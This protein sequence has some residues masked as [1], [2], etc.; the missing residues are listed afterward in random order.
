MKRKPIFL[1]I[2]LILSMLLSFASCSNGGLSYTDSDIDSMISELE[3]KIDDL[4]AEIDDLEAEIDGLKTENGGLKTEIDALKAEINELKAKIDQLL[5]DGYRVVT[6]DANGGSTV[7]SQNVHVGTRAEEPADP[8][9]E[10]YEFDG[11]YTS[12]GEYWDFDEYTVHGNI[13]LI[14]K[15]T[16]PSHGEPADP[17]ANGHSYSKASGKCKKCDA[18]CEHSFG[19]DSVCDVCGYKRKD[20]GNEAAYPEVPW[21]NDEPIELLFS[22]SLNSSNK[23]LSSGA[24][25]FLAGEDED[26]CD[27]IDEDVW[28][29]NSYAYEYTNVNLT[30]D[31]WPDTT[32]YGWGKCFD[33]IYKETKVT[34]YK[35]P[36]MYS[37][38]TYDMVAASLKGSFHNLK[39]TGLKDGNYFS[40]LD[41]DYQEDYNQY[42]RAVENGTADE[43]TTYDDKGYMY[44]YMQSLTLN[45]EKSYVLASDYFTD[46]IRAFYVVPVNVSLLE[47]VGL[48]ITGDRDRD[49]KFTLDDFYIEVNNREW[50]YQKV[51][52]YSAA[53]YRNTGTFSGA[54]DIEDVLGWCSNNG[55]FIASGFIYS[56]DINVIQRV[57]NDSIGDYEYSYPD[58]SQQLYDIFDAISRLHQSTGVYCL[59]TDDTNFTKY[60][61]NT[62]LAIAVLNRFC[63]NKILFGGI[64]MLGSLE[65]PEYQQLKGSGGFGVV[66]VPL[67]REVDTTVEYDPINYL[68]SIHNA[69]RPGAISI[70]T[71]NFAACTAFLDYQST[72]STEILDSYYNR[73]LCVKVVDGEVEGTVKM[74]KYIR[75]N[76]RSAFDETFEDVLGVFDSKVSPYNW[77]TPLSSGKFICDIRDDYKSYADKKEETLLLLYEAYKGLP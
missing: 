77:T 56:T 70:T 19:D 3:G 59:T 63:D 25:R 48:G 74:L 49:G 54:E 31:Y 66:P 50:T 52:D 58:E 41:K 55:G 42:I 13:T 40:F 51:I 29:R 71:K 20:S 47:S 72:H 17:C 18:V 26:Y 35:T 46:V 44:E 75:A 6:F 5:T 43:N 10:G 36:D 45:Q 32:E 53:I 60:G 16:E 12:D 34:G 76:V 4:E 57:W 21:L 27:T 8:T 39:N 62:K 33:L 37:N 69:A 22:M 2:L 23:Q 9:R 7:E 1:P 24:K 68:T 61:S 64:I 38:F 67:Y 14:A 15:W 73:Y 30:Y 65:E 28:D 11:W